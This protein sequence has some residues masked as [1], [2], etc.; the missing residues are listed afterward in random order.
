MVSLRNVKSEEQTR[1]SGD[2]LFHARRAAATGK[3]RSLRAARRVDGTPA[4]SWCQQRGDSNERR[5]LMPAAGCQTDT[6]VLWHA[7]NGTQEHTTGTGFA[8]GRATSEALVAVELCLLM[9]GASRQAKLRHSARTAVGP[10][11]IQRF[12]IATVQQ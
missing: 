11:R 7:H 6:P 2:R 5:C 1:V 4:V 8:L 3:A 9:S 12:R 10:A